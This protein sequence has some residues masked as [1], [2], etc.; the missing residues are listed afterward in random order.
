[1]G[2]APHLREV[3]KVPREAPATVLAGEVRETDGLLEEAR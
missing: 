1:V 3:L 2:P